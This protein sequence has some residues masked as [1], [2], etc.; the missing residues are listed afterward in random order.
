VIHVPDDAYPGVFDEFGRELQPHGLLLVGFH[1]GDQTQHTS[2]G[3]TGRPINVDSHHRRPGTVMG[4]LRDAGFSIEAEMILRPD[5]A[6][7][8]AVIFASSDG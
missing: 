4:W 1:V 6:V 3:Y 2:K 7:P 5:E 8:G